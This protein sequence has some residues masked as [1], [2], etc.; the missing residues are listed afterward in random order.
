MAGEFKRDLSE[1]TFFTVKTL[2]L[3]ESSVNLRKSFFILCRRPHLTIKG[4]HMFDIL[5]WFAI[6]FNTIL[7]LGLK[8]ICANFER[9]IRYLKNNKRNFIVLC[10]SIYSIQH[11]LSINK[12]LD[13]F[14]I[15]F[16]LRADSVNSR[17][18]I[19]L[20]YGSFKS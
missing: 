18:A 19:M 11:V 20:Y 3:N 15:L 4:E 7:F 5:P 8:Y 2:L 9:Q 6:S 10:M 13:S 1:Y 17:N 12:K 14:L 16:V